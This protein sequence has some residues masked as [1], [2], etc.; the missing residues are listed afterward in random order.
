LEVQKL[1]WMLT[2]VIP[3]CGLLDPLKLEFVAD[4]YGPYAHQLTHLLNALDG[5][6]LHCDKRLADASP[7]DN[8]YFE[9]DRAAALRAYPPPTEHRLST[10][11]TRLTN[12][13][14]VSSRHLEWKRWLPWTGC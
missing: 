12:S 8:I 7:F 11:L 6:Y 5:S 10:R 4:R 1:A 14:T 3:R 13:S 9:V 2:R